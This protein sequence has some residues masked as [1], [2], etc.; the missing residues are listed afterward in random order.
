MNCEPIG[1]IHSPFKDMRQIPRQAS[2]V[3]S[4]GAYIELTGPVRDSLIGLEEFSHIWI[5]GDFH[6]ALNKHPMV[7]PPRL[8]G[9]WKGVYATRAP[10]RANSISL[11]IAE[12]DRIVWPRIYIRGTDL[13]DGTPVLDIKPYIPMYDSKPLAKVPEWIEAYEPLGPFTFKYA[14]LEKICT[15]R[16]ELI[17]CI[18]TD[19]RTKKLRKEQKRDQKPIAMEFDAK[20]LKVFYTIMPDKSVTIDEIEKVK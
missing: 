14:T 5:L 19:L 4:L 15:A 9:G 3:P 10:N 1:I 2:L 12:I 13:L 6:Q 8:N 11:S 18:Q 16:P 20:D 7:Q 17:E